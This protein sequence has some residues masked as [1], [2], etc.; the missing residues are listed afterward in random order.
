MEEF[1][2]AV[3]ELIP[4][5]TSDTLALQHLNTMS[6]QPTNKFSNLG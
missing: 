3:P 5:A 4:F 6:V 2:P 1:S